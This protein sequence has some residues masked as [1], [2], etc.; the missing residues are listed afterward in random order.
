[1]QSSL[2]VGKAQ[3]LV[4]IPGALISPQQATQSFRKITASSAK[5]ITAVI[6]LSGLSNFMR[7]MCLTIVEGIKNVL[8]SVDIWRLDILGVVVLVFCSAGF[9]G[10]GS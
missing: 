5:S 3:M 1:M 8:L 4:L 7:Y 9:P 10:S 6:S 2:L